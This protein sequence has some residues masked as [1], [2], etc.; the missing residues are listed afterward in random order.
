MFD[1]IILLSPYSITLDE[2]NSRYAMEACH[3]YNIQY[4]S[5]LEEYYNTGGKMLIASNFIVPYGLLSHGL[6]WIRYTNNLLLDWIPAKFSESYFQDK[7]RPIEVDQ[8]SQHTL[9]NNVSCIEYIGP[10]LIIDTDVN[11]LAWLQLDFGNGT[12]IEYNFLINIE[13]NQSG[14][15]LVLSASEYFLSNNGLVSSDFAESHSNLAL[16]IIEWLLQ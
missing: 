7:G 14:G 12:I 5:C 15:R 11:S 8:L 10:H 1:A 3:P 6:D 13:N 16:N 4:T 9:M 2:T